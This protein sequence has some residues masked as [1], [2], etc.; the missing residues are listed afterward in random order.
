MTRRTQICRNG[1]DTV[2]V[3]AYVSGICH[4]CAHASSRRRR[5]KVK[6]RVIDM[7]GGQCACCSEKN[8]GFLT[9]DHINGDGQ[10]DRK[11][12]KA[13]NIYGVLVNTPL[14][15]DLRVL[16]YNCN[17]GRRW[18]DVCPHEEEAT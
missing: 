1:H 10:A 4:A 13:A 18:V 5:K 8:I 15:S 16:C 2:V 12:L 3:G 11:R 7:Y 14:R 9:I 6:R 17:L